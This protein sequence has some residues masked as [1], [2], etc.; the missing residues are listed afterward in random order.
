MLYFSLLSLAP[1]WQGIQLLNV[2]AFMEHYQEYQAESK[3]GDVISFIK[4][5]YFN[6]FTDFDKD[7]EKLPLKTTV[8]VA[9]V[10]FTEEFQ[11]PTPVVNSNVELCNQ[12]H[13]NNSKLISFIGNDFHS[14]WQP[15]QLG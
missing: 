1:N 14:I 11:E 7:H 4:E 3:D 15:P 13:K 8:Q 12:A 2:S 5:H 9:T 10:Y 6:K